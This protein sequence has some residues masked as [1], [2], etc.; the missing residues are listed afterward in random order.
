MTAPGVWTQYSTV[1]H[2]LGTL[3]GWVPAIDQQRIASYLKYDQIYWSAEEG[4]EQVL[5]GDNE[6][7]V[8][9]PTARTLVNTLDRYTCPKFSYRLEGTDT[10]TVDLLTGVLQS[11]FER[12][13]FISLFNAF[14]LEGGKLGD[15][16]LHIV[17]DMAKPLGRRISLYKVDP[18]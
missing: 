13:M 9:L 3:P 10:A 4:Y 17:A 11:L 2:L 18:A 8:F 5:R 6:N 16:L 15:A 7:P 14:K 1:D 12:E